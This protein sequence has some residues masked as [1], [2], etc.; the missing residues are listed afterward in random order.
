[1]EPFPGE[2]PSAG[3]LIQL[4]TTSGWDSLESHA[5]VLELKGGRLHTDAEVRPHV[6]VKLATLGELFGMVI[7]DTSTG[8]NATRIVPLKASVSED[9]RNWPEVFRTDK[10]GDPRRVAFDGK[11]LRSD[12][13]K[14]DRDDDRREVFRLSAIHV[15]GYKLK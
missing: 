15:Y 3:G 2:L 8:Y 14:I 5:G 1:M 12:W 6:I 9:G 10:A 13:V 4:P 7:F 11:T